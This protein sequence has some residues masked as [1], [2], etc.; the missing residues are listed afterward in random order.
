MFKKKKKR[1]IA[2]LRVPKYRFFLLVLFKQF[3]FLLTHAKI[4]A[5]SQLKGLVSAYVSKKRTAVL[6]HVNRLKVYL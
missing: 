5:F 3:F 6:G 4:K 1:Q 2:G